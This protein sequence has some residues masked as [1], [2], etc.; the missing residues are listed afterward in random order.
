MYSEH[1]L[2][3]NSATSLAPRPVHFNDF[4]EN[5]GFLHVAGVDDRAVVAVGEILLNPIEPEFQ[6]VG[7][8]VFPWGYRLL[9]RSSSV[10]GLLATS[11]S[12]SF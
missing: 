10:A 7:E 11:Q 1:T 6:L 5:C 2:E 8:A 12:I 9:V 4:P 3:L